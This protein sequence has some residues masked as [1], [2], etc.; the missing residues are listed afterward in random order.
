MK[1]ATPASSTLTEINLS[2]EQLNRGVAILSK[3]DTAERAKKNND[4]I[5]MA[6]SNVMN[7]TRYFVEM[8]KFLQETAGDD[9]QRHKEVVGLVLV[10]YYQRR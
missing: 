3:N 4:H 10:E 9:A 5:P 7:A 1:I 2:E 8:Q 6:V